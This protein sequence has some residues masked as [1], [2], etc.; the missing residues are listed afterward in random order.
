MR[1]IYRKAGN[2]FLLLGTSLLLTSCY[3]MMDKGEDGPVEYMIAVHGGAG[4]MDAEMPEAMQQAY[5]AA[6]R[7]ALLAG[8]EVLKAGGTAVEAVEAAIRVMEDDSL[9][10]A[11]KGAV[12]NADGQHELDA[13]IMEGKFHTAGAV[14]GVRQVRNPITA[15]RL[16]MTETPHVMLVGP[17]AD[18]FAL[19]M[20]MD[21]V[22]SSYFWTTRHRTRYQEALAK[23]G[24]KLGTVGAV[25]RDRDGNLAAGTSTGGMAMKKYGRVGDSPVIGAGTWADNATCAVSCTGHGE[26]FIRYGVAHELS[27]LM[28]HRKWPLERAANH[29]VMQE[30]K[31]MD[32]SGGLIAVDTYGNIVMPFNTQGMFRG[33]VKEGQEPLTYIFK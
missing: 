7:Q 13:S 21:P 26:Y 22:D 28:E 6:L 25:A 5:H 2:V 27:S 29:L 23:Q 9:F 14:A 10:N 19:E 18:A 11:G 8:E 1:N 30:L 24:K 31:T 12:Y 15:A 32:A 4:S 17:G 3:Y 33:Y 20:G 16:V